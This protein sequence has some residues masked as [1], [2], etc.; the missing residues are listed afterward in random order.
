MTELVTLRQPRDLGRV[1][2]DS[3]AVLG[4]T[5]TQLC[6][7]VAPAVL[8]SILIALISVLVADVVWLSTVFLLISLPIDLMAYELV[9]AAGIALLIAREQ[10]QDIS[11]GD[12]LDAAQDRFRAVI[13]AAFKTTAISVLLCLTIIGI[14]WAIKRL[15]LWAFIIQAIMLDRQTGEASLGYSAGL[16]KGHW[17]NTFGRL[18]ACFLVAG[19]PALIVSQIVLEAV[20]GTLGLILSSTA[21]FI[22]LPFGI[23]ATTLL[24]FD[25]KV[26]GAANDDLSPA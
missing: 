12:A 3:F 17:W 25:L 24:Y 19:I 22:S 16:V 9:S 10:R 21:S 23:I 11:T 5:W 20:P 4:A 18:V 7:V 2:S 8:V 15:V 13:V 6:V 26:R 14:P 1:I